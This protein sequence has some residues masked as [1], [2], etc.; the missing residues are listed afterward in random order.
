[1]DKFID[2]FLEWLENYGYECGG[3]WELIN[4]IED[5]NTEA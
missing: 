4:D 3:Y 2:D 1:M 5:Q